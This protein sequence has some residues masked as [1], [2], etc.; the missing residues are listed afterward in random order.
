MDTNLGAAV[1]WHPVRSGRAWGSRTQLGAAAVNTSAANRALL[2]WIEQSYG[3]ELAELVAVRA[4]QLAA[5][6]AVPANG[7]GQAED[8]EPAGWF[9]RITDAVTEIAPKYLEYRQQAEILDV[10]LDR[11]REG[12]PPLRTDEY[13]PS[14]QLGLDPE[15]VERIADEAA[16]RAA[17]AGQALM[18]S[19]ALWIGAGVLGFMMLRAMSDG[20]DAQ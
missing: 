16:R 8:D 3:P 10:Q 18:Q 7:L 2:Q 11:A 5:R 14:V 6:N 1:R 9:E 13:A 15:T 4:Q 17:G 19:P 20:R 12:L